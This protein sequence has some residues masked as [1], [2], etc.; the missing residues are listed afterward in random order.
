[1]IILRGM[2]YRETSRIITAFSEGFGII[3]LIA[4]GVRNPKSRMAAAL[5]SLVNS[6]IVFYKK[7]QSELYLVKE[8]EIMEFFKNIHN[9]LIRYNYAIIIIDF[10]ST[11]LAQEQVS[12]TLYQYSLFILH[13]IDRKPKDELPYILTCFLL[14][15][16]SLLGFR[17]ELEKC[18]TCGM[19]NFSPLYFSNAKG[20]IIC[21]E[22]RR[23]DPDT[24]KITNKVLLFL[25]NVQQQKN[26]EHSQKI[27]PDEFNEI[28][29]LLSDW[30]RYHNHKMIKTLDNYSKGLDP[31]PYGTGVRPPLAK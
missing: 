14:K 22:C 20:G 1:M 12:K 30:F 8:A 27:N 19:K 23:N 21:Q 13:S 9:N 4:K 15:G 25:K 16:A 18:T 24:T 5:Q 6:E 11:L 26:F 3:K 29:S 31:V 2:D 7:E 17:I 10:L 28:F